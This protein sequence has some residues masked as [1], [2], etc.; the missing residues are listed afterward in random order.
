MKHNVL[1]IKNV[2]KHFDGVKAVD[3]F[4][5]EINQGEIICITGGNGAGKTTLFNLITGFEKVD[6]GSI[7]FKEQ[8]VTKY[9]P[10]LRARTGISRLFQTPRIFNHLTVFENILAAAPNHP[11]EKMENYLL[12]KFRKIRNAEN[13]IRKKA[14]DLLEFC[15]LSDKKNEFASHLSFGQKK[16]LGLAML[17]MND[18]E[19]LLLDEIYSGVNKN[20]IEKINELLLKLSKTGKTF[21]IIEHRIKEIQKIC[22]R[23]LFMEQGKM[24]FSPLAISQQK[25]SNNQYP[26]TNTQLLTQN[27]SLTIENLSVAYNTNTILN[28][29]NI[30]LHEGEVLGIIGENGCGKSTLLK[31]VYS[32]LK[33]KSG[34]ITYKETDITKLPPYDKQKTGIAFCLQGGLIFPELS[35]YE[36]FRLVSENQDEYSTAFNYF[37]ELKEFLKKRA[38]NLSGGQRQ[39]LS[40]SMLLL[41]NNNAGVWMLDEPTAGLSADNVLI[42]LNFLHEVKKRNKIS[43]IIVEHN[44]DFIFKMIDTCLIIKNGTNTEK[45]NSTEFLEPNFLQNNLYT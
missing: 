24:S 20:M 29:I 23:I 37:P 25:T 14:L 41:Q 31:S 8:D 17:L 42:T 4:S 36:H 15:N 30:E 6:E 43:I 45:Y 40:L 21:L 27:N 10:T 35:V 28:N 13:E 3:G 34:K 26:I 44:Y 5:L 33:S 18:A 39:M 9:S 32:L 16:L 12:F 1:H 7:I 19:L 11:G 38:G 2:S 22:N